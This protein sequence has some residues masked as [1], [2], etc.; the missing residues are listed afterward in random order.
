MPGII[1][2]ITDGTF[3][4]SADAIWKAL[5]PGQYLDGCSLQNSGC[6]YLERVGSVMDN[7]SKLQDS[8]SSSNSSLVCHIHLRPKSIEVGLYPPIFHPAMG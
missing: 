3:L 1:K 7:G 8:E 5:K 2:T 4:I 6:C